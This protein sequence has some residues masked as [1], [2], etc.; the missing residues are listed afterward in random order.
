MSALL[1]IAH[2]LGGLLAI[3]SSAYLL[4]LVWAI[5]VDDGT[6]RSFALSGAATLVAGALLFLVGRR[7]RRELLPRDGVLAVTLGWLLMALAATG[8]LLLEIPGLSFTDALFE[9]MSGLTTTGASVLSG[10]ENLPPSINL[11]RHALNWFGGMGLIV[12]A[13]AILPMLGVGGMQLFKAETPGPIKES[14]LTPRI[15]QTAKYLWLIYAVLTGLCIAALRLAGLDWLDAVCHAFSAVALGGFSTRDASVSAFDSPVVESVL[16]VF[17]VISVLN[18]S[19]HFV[20]LRQR[21]LRVYVRDSEVFAVWGLML[22][23]V[24]L[25]TGFLAWRGS[26][27]SLGESFRHAAFNV[28]SLAT[29]TGYM[30]EDYDRWPVFAAS[31]LLL[32]GIVGSS[33]G[34]TGGG[35]KMIRM[36]ILL[37]H[38]GNELVRLMHPR[39]VTPLRLSGQIVDARVVGAVMGFM[40]LWGLSL[41]VV[42]MLLMATGL[43]AMTAIS[44]AIACLNNIGP[45]L[46]MVGPAQNYAPLTDFQ[47]WLCSFAMLAG[48]LEL[49]TVFVLFTP[50]F[51]RK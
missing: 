34:S 41:V 44:A 26:Y 2:V 14:K 33:S 6:Q 22:F 18:F 9:T 17:M 49:L 37:R 27:D 42:S 20:A 5:V 13:V 1:N 10:L 45:G 12:L 50:A 16:A 23:S 46:S 35:I 32:L 31:W 29:S 15:T 21:S 51:W 7:H 48:R 43:D 8:P 36:M 4:P 40:L 24:L 30:G 39:A 28:I 3:F 11:W 19:T 38:A 47:T 25:L